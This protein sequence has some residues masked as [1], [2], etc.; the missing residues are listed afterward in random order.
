MSLPLA[1]KA[2]AI[3]S[4]EYRGH[5]VG[6]VPL[7]LDATPEQAAGMAAALMSRELQGGVPTAGVMRFK[8]ISSIV[9]CL[10][11]YKFDKF[12]AGKPC[13]NAVVMVGR[14]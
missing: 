7:G 3:D 10:Q 12:A 13:F 6:V 11:G 14:W 5:W 2:T 1:L 9:N 4:I 8:S